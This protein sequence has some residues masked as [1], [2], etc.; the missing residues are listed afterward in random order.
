MS[1]A[2]KM[3]NIPFKLQYIARCRYNAV[4]FLQ[5]P[6]GRA[7]GCLLWVSSLIH[8]LLLSLEYCV[9]YRDKLD[10]VIT[11]LDCIQLL[12]LPYWRDIYTCTQTCTT[13][14]TNIVFSWLYPRKQNQMINILIHLSNIFGHSCQTEN[15]FYIMGVGEYVKM[16]KH[17]RLVSLTLWP[18]HSNRINLY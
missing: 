1:T 16:C 10:R 6:D 17:F 12:V 18:G 13:L 11:A 14:T 9:W 3:S 4:N 2:C 5:Y 7:V 15:T 8:V